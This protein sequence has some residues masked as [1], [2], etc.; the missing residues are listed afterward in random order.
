[1]RYN[2]DMEK[3]DLNADVA[4]GRKTVG[5]AVSGG[6]DS[7]ALL[8][9]L[10]SA[11]VRVK[12]INVEHGIRGEAS[13][14]D[15]AFVARICKQWDV[16]LLFYT[17]NAP[18]FAR[19]EG[20]TLE[21]AARIL[22]YRAFE[23]AL[24]E[25]CDYIALA[26]HVEDQTETLFMRILRG[27]GLKGLKGMSKVSGR[28]L[29][30]LLDMTRED[31]DA[32]IAEH[33]LEYVEDETNSDPAYTRNFLREELSRLRERFPGLDRAFARLSSNATE[34]EDFIRAQLPETQVKDNE[35]FIKTTYFANCAIAKRLIVDGAE[36]L[37]VRQDI[38][39]RH[40]KSVLALALAENGKRVC[41]PHGLVAHKD[42]EHVVLSRRSAVCEDEA[43]EIDGEG[44]Y[45]YGAVVEELSSRPTSFAGALYIDA[46]KLPEG[47]EIRLRR[48][49][50]Y[51]CKFGGGTKS[52][53]DFLT[54]KKVPKRMRDCLPVIAF[55][56]EAYAIFGVD[57]SKKVAVEADS[58][59][60]WKLTLDQ[61]C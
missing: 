41:L 26:H 1:M 46:D 52:V 48:D 34:A 38:E 9:M 32:Y 14:R 25:G 57:I 12:A 47:A 18:E 7:V 59:R 31:I 39:D 36:A 5:V 10:K 44:R 15:S 35:V 30:P 6:R 24:N 55:G 21:Q 3:L 50:D 49:G 56:S 43:V 60:I 58:R 33:G 51:I 16:P 2:F 54:D 40:I 19:K 11:G 27:T 23:E 42:G 61:K 8:H 13:K 22:R 29:R 53:G 17:V 28:Y 4:L 20:Y 37:D 45:P